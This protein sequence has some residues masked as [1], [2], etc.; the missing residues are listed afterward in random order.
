M[1]REGHAFSGHIM[2]SIKSETV[3]I[4]KH[5]FDPIDPRNVNQKFEISRFFC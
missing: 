3:K 1:T 4:R 5:I 2:P